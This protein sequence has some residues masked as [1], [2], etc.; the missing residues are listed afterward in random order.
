[1]NTVPVILH[2]DAD[3]FFASV[4]QVLDVR[5]KGK[6]VVTGSTRGAATSISYEAKARGVTRGMT[7]REVKRVC[8]DVVLV[9]GN[10]TAYSLFAKRMYTIVRSFTP[11]VEEYSIDECFADITHLE[12][13][14][15]RSYEDIV[16]MM[17]ARL[18]EELGITYG[19]GLAHTKTLAKVASKHQKPAGFVSLLNEAD[20][21]RVLKETSITR[22]WGLGGVSGLHLEKLGVATAYDFTEKDEA[23]LYAKHFAKPYRE[24]WNELRGVSV[25]PLDSGAR[26]MMGSIMKTRSFRPTKDPSLVRRELSKNIE[27]ACEKA[28]EAGVKARMFSYYLKTND[29]IFIRR[30]HTLPVPLNDPRELMRAIDL[31]ESF[32][33]GELYRTTGVT[34]L[35]LVPV[36]H[37]TPDLFQTSSALSKRAPALLA[38]DTLNKRYGRHTVHLGSS[39]GAYTSARDT[40]NKADGLLHLPIYR[41]KALSIP[42]LGIVR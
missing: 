17:K 27:L 13:R 26:R 22:V 37:E 39:L 10:Y 30:T 34:L 16:R 28:R 4:E 3:A 20:A 41:K 32:E 31:Y 1:M 6:P 19:V 15:G 24:I 5:L 42:Y 2:F 8:P 29:F 33:P 23:W 40:R 38:M 9:P 18:E 7:M 11:Y 35:S 12:G 36:S 14:Y 21:T 25:K